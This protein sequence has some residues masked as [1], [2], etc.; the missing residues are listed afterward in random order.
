[1]VLYKKK[2]ATLSNPLVLPSEFGVDTKVFVIRETGEWFPRYKDYIKRLWFYM[3]NNFTCEITSHTNLTFFQAMASEEEEFNK[4]EM[5][6]PIKIRAPMAEFLHF[7]NISRF[8]LL[9][10]EA[11]FKFKNLFF[12]DEV[13][14]L[15][16]MNITDANGN[17]INNIS[18]NIFVTDF[19][20]NH[21]MYFD[22]TAA[23]SYQ[24][25]NGSDPDSNEIGVDLSNKWEVKEILHMGPNM[26]PKY[27]IYQPS[28]FIF[29]EVDASEIRRE[30]KT[31]T[32]NLVRSFM[33]L[34]LEKASRKNGSPWR[35]KE[36]YIQHYDLS[37]EWPAQFLKYKEPI[38][39]GRSSTELMDGLP[40]KKRGRPK[41]STIVSDEKTSKKK[42]KSA[43]KEGTP[44]DLKIISMEQK[45]LND[46]SNVKQVDA[47]KPT[48]EFKT[49]VSVK[50]NT[51]Q[52][53]TEES[54]PVP[55]P[56]IVYSPNLAKV[57]MTMVNDNE[58][59][60]FLNKLTDMSM[61][62]D[63]LTK[64]KEDVIKTV[65]EHD[66][67]SSPKSDEELF[68][69]FD[70]LYYYGEVDK[71]Q[72]LLEPNFFRRGLKQ[73][74]VNFEIKKFIRGRHTHKHWDFS[75]ILR[76]YIFLINFNEVLCMDIPPFQEYLVLLN[77]ERQRNTISQ[78]E[79]QVLFKFTNKSNDD[80]L[81]LIHD[82]KT[83]M[84]QRLFN[85]ST[86]I[87][88][89]L[90]EQIDFNE[91]EEIDKR[92]SSSNKFIIELICCL[93]RLF[94]NE[95]GEWTVE[96]PNQWYSNE[97]KTDITN[98][99]AISNV[100]KE[101]EIEFLSTCAKYKDVTFSER[102][103]K[104]NF[105]NG[106]WCLILLGIIEDSFHLLPF[107]E[108]MKKI[109]TGFIGDESVYDFKALN[110]KLLANFNENF[111]MNECL[112]I[113]YVLM[114]IVINYG[115]DIKEQIDKVSD[116][117]TF[118]KSER[119]K[120]TK[121][122]KAAIKDK[123]LLLHEQQGKKSNIKEG[124]SEQVSVELT[125]LDKKI[126]SI[127]REIK[128]KEQIKEFWENKVRTV[129][130]LRTKSL[131][132]DR[133]GNTYWFLE[134]HGP[135]DLNTFG[136]LKGGE[137][138]RSGKLFIQ[139]PRKSDI[140]LYYNGLSY[141]EYLQ[142]IEKY[143]VFDDGTI[144]N[145]E[146]KLILLYQRLWNNNYTN[147]DLSV[148]DWKFI[149]YGKDFLVSDDDWCFIDDDMILED[150]LNW[151]NKFGS[152]EKHIKS[153]I[154]SIL[155]SYN[156]DELNN[157]LLYQEEVDDE[158]SQQL[159]KQIQEVYES[160]DED[161]VSLLKKLG[162]NSKLYDVWNKLI[163]ETLSKTNEEPKEDQISYLNG[164][165]QKVSESLDETKE[166]IRKNNLYS[167]KSP[168]Q[169]ELF[170]SLTKTRES[171]ISEK[172][173]ILNA[174]DKY[175]EQRREHDIELSLALYQS[176]DQNDL[177]N[178]FEKSDT[179]K[180]I[181]KM[182]H[183][184]NKML[185]NLPHVDIGDLRMNY[186]NG[187]AMKYFKKNIQDGL[188]DVKKNKKKSSKSYTV[189]SL[190]ERMEETRKELTTFE[191]TDRILESV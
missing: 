87:D 73:Y 90:S 160:I 55:K 187:M 20:K 3:H 163:S 147:E 98:E 168:K 38:K 174:I 46:V 77:N 62:Q 172:Q 145:D 181:V 67:F 25:M 37:P 130:Q 11:Y 61:L 190:K 63:S 133:Y 10:E 157:K 131:G 177:S 183:I 151:F 114:E 2:K 102:L 18:D 65:K 30:R 161:D 137:V 139:G 125:E 136:K 185:K 175:K 50:E 138:K 122:L 91:N 167:V 94:I 24:I 48:T 155:E 79:K 7:N 153:N 165:L 141:E 189:K 71:H 34:T 81:S 9:L 74:D 178:I 173:E 107:Q 12:V 4:L 188:T 182:N 75:L 184:V 80:E 56:K 97:L 159:M 152:S 108:K 32:R 154:M 60:R 170:E 164:K 68:E 150:L 121:S 111:K 99:E 116:F 123:N 95:S 92:T 134:T 112:E 33:K 100:L 47:V 180:K 15:K 186:T 86:N 28:S 52:V 26:P 23:E 36:D 17:I 89:A 69:L 44:K 41:S 31:Y 82:L 127:G 135:F 149:D 148:L 22:R 103:M 70:S 8:D 6:F 124:E 126:D 72:K 59:P 191:S 115:R 166:K 21:N 27:R 57:K 156:K 39:Y 169:Q 144:I 128:Q 140:S 143:K 54:I 110:T 176:G 118:L 109:V 96:V 101:R 171:L 42:I 106:N 117:T 179:I 19:L 158:I 43:D 146:S 93:L 5:R 51:K 132:T 78:G 76:V 1:M 16:D 85:S 119:F 88:I 13:V 113:I 35:V 49:S 45:I 162:D 29:I 53:N 104:R 83:H 105:A 14:F 84:S 64:T 120:S 142:K 58:I 40:P 129:H 66:K